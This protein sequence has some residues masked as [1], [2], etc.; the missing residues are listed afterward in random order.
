MALQGLVAPVIF[1][2]LHCAFVFQ[3]P[4]PKVVVE[5]P[6]PE[7]KE[8]KGKAIA[9]KKDQGKEDL[10]KKNDTALEMGKVKRKKKLKVILLC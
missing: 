3:P 1:N 7:V 4:P 9:K 2:N 8:N 5:P 6:K 10:L